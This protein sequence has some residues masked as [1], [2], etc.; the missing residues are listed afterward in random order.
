MP[1]RQS[2]SVPRAYRRALACQYPGVC[3]LR[4]ACLPAART[5]WPQGNPCAHA[6]DPRPVT[7]E[8]PP[9]PLAIPIGIQTSKETKPLLTPDAPA[10]SINCLLSFYI[11]SP[12]KGFFSLSPLFFPFSLEPTQS[13]LDKDRCSICRPDVPQST[14]TNSTQLICH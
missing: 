2:G 3:R 12:Q 1:P 6:L 7:T 14:S 10:A 9:R 11:K 13:D 8:V 4:S 5:D